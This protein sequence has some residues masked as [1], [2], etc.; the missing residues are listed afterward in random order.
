VLARRAVVLRLAKYWHASVLD[1]VLVVGA[2]LAN[3]LAG[4]DILRAT[5]CLNVTSITIIW[6]VDIRVKLTSQNSQVL[7]R[8]RAKPTNEAMMARTGRLAISKCG[9]GNWHGPC[10]ASIAGICRKLPEIAGRAFAGAQLK[11]CAARL[12]FVFPLPGHL[13][14]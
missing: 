1:C 8:F 5:V 7:L 6:P 12:T 13:Q 10:C 11:S 4:D 9:N 14:K 3:S 2:F